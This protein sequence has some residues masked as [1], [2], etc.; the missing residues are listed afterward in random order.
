[1][2]NIIPPTIMHTISNDES[3]GS[4]FGSTH[5]FLSAL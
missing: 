3:D 5:Y 4:I 2:V 1:M